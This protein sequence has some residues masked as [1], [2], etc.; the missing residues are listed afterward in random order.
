M[1]VKMGVFFVPILEPRLLYGHVLLG[2]DPGLELPV[3]AITAPSDF[4]YLGHQMFGNLDGFSPHN[5]SLDQHIV[6]VVSIYGLPRGPTW[7]RAAA[8]TIDIMDFILKEFIIG[9]AGIIVIAGDFN[10]GPRELQSFEAWRAFGFCSAQDMA[11]NHVQPTCKG[12]TERDMLWLSPMAASLC[13]SIRVDEVFSD[14]ASLSVELDLGILQP[15]IHTWPRPREIPWDQVQLQ[16]WHQH[17]DHLELTLPHCSTEAMKELAHSFE[18]SLKGFVSDH[19]SESLSSAHCGRAQR[20][21]PAK[22]TPTPRSCRASRPGEEHIAADTVSKAVLLWFKQLRKLQSYRHSIVAGKWHPAA[23]QYRSELWS[24]IRRSPGFEGSFD[25]WWLQQDFAQVLGPLPLQPPDVNLAI[26][27]FQAFHQAYR[28]FERWHLQ[29]RQQAQQAR[30][31]KT[32]KAIF[33][34]LRQARPDQVDAF[35][36]TLSFD[37]VAIKPDTSGVLLDKH[38]PP[39]LQGQWFKDN[40][41]PRKGTLKSCWFLKFS[42]NSHGVTL[43]SSTPTPPPQQ[44]STMRFRSFGLHDG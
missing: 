6:T 3:P 32:M 20:L 27:I 5:T 4:K 10:F 21:A 37:V 9:N 30:Y 14:H 17:C 43:W 1:P 12:S 15:S 35:W 26:L 44:K 28:D 33:V 16:D 40:L 8:I 25:H 38:V 7:P 39:H 22:L 11:A 2:L 31:D 42:L 13:S 18:Q 19:P 23:V 24:S 41:S 34:D 36:D 29:Q